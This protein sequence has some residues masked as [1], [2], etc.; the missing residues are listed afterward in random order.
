MLLLGLLVLGF[1]GKGVDYYRL[2]Q[3]EE[4]LRTQFTQEY[5]QIRPGDTRD[6][7]DPVGAVNSIRQG[8]GAGTA[9]PVFLASLNE[10][11][12][13]LSQNGT[14]QVEAV[15]YRAGVIDVRVTT[16]DVETVGNI[17]KA[18]GESGQFVASIQ[19]TD[20]IAD[21]INSRI[22]IREAGS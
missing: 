5:R 15:S 9:T 20:R 21:R 8:L 18:I 2:T 22:Q 7:M 3:E 17:Q 14:A 13:A 11:A 10:L 1:A 6:V 4:A 16:P 19:S 12:A